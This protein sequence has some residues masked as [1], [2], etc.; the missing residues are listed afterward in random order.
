MNV[1]QH[2]DP[3]AQTQ[4]GGHVNDQVQAYTSMLVGHASWIVVQLVFSQKQTTS[5]H[6]RVQHQK[7][8]FAGQISAAQ[9]HQ[10]GVKL[11]NKTA[12]EHEAEAAE[13]M[14]ATRGAGNL[15][16]GVETVDRGVSGKLSNGSRSLIPDAPGGH[17]STEKGGEDNY[18]LG[19]VVRLLVMCLFVVIP[20]HNC[21][22]ATEKNK[23]VQAIFWPC[24]EKAAN[25]E[26]TLTIQTRARVSENFC[27]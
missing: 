16:E 5:Q 21:K 11:H 18:K 17:I 1:A 24:L 23:R 13:A 15:H 14:K 10:K 6:E 3:W 27:P 9:S 25:W 12:V 8:R 26:T 7:D 19:I 20:R 4:Q 22:R 2:R